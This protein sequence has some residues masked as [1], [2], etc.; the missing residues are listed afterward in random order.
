MDKQKTK[1]RQLV[2]KVISNKMNK[3]VVVLVERLVKHALYH[4]YIR[5]R[6]KYAAH[7]ENNSCSIGDK[8]LII[9]SRPISKSKKWKVSKIIEKA[10]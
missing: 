9:E 6:S 8:V 3:T 1:K 5:R 2:G 10:A 7:N 4:K